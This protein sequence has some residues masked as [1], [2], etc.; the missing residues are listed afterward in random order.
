MLN[1][2]NYIFVLLLNCINLPV[3]Q[4]SKSSIMSNQALFGSLRK[5]SKL[6]FKYF[7]VLTKPQIVLADKSEGWN[8]HMKSKPR[9]TDFVLVRKLIFLSNL[10]Q[11]F[12]SSSLIL[13]IP[14]RQ[15]VQD[16]SGSSSWEIVVFL[17]NNINF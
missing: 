16:C 4:L 15:L 1:I 3:P 17:I 13:H 14:A 7:G 12:L 10:V 9:N 2:V 8:F 11:Q 5:V 6:Y